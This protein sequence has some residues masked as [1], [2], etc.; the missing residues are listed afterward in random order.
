M[1]TLD[2]AVAQPGNPTLASAT[3]APPR[4]LR[5]LVVMA[6]HMAQSSLRMKVEELQSSQ[7]E[8]EHIQIDTSGQQNGIGLGRGA[9]L[10]DALQIVY[11]EPCKQYCRNG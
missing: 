8:V 6:L 9:A 3:A 11:Q 5:R 1:F 7:E 4:N 10:G 2:F